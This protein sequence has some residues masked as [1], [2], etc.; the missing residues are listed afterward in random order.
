MARRRN[1]S[2]EN[3]DGET[4]G[5]GKL[6]QNLENANFSGAKL[7]G[8]KFQKANLR[9]A[10]F[11][12]AEIGGAKFKGANLKGANFTN[13]SV[14]LDGSLPE[15]DFSHTHIEGT[16]FSDAVLTRANFSYAETGLSNVGR[17]LI[18]VITFLISIFSAFPTAIITTFSTYF[19]RAPRKKPSFTEQFLVGIYAFIFTAFLRTLLINFN[20]SAVSIFLVQIGTA[21][22]VV[23]LVGA[24]IGIAKDGFKGDITSTLSTTLP[25]LIFLIINLLL[26]AYG[27]TLGFDKGLAALFPALKAIVPTLG[28]STQ[29]R[30]FTAI[31]GALIGAPFGSWFAKSAIYGD[32]KF[33]WLWDTYMEFAARS[34]TLFISAD[35]TD[36]NFVSAQVRGA[37]F[38]GA[39]LRRTN[40][41]GSRSLNFVLHENCYL[42]NPEI[43]KIIRGER[44]K[45]RDFS[46]LNLEGVNLENASL[47]NAL[48][49]E[50]NLNYA[51]LKGCNLNEA[52]FN[53]ARLV[54]ANLTEACLTG[55]CIEG[56]KIDETTILDDVIC[57]YV[58]KEKLPG[59]MAGR[60]REPPYPE[61]FKSG[62]F[63]E[64]YGKDVETV[65]FRIRKSD[66]QQALDIALRE[67]VQS[68]PE[69]RPES[70][71]QIKSIGDD[72]II[73]IRV[74][75]RTDKAS[76]EQ[77]FQRV[78]E[79]VEKERAANSEPESYSDLPPLEFVLNVVKELKEIM[80]ST[81]SS[82][83]INIDGP[84]GNITDN[85]YGDQNS[86]QTVYYNQNQ[87]KTIVE[88]AREIQDLIKQLEQSSPSA[89][90]E[91]KIEYVNEQAPAILRQ[92]IVKS[93]Q[94]GGIAAIDEVLENNA[95]VSVIRAVAKAWIEEA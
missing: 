8:A 64:K 4:F 48:F 71:Q 66:N 23:V 84:V 43:R 7:R 94:A 33:D 18:I 79:S 13:A 35:L 1:Y 2:G 55:A 88:S 29:D 61:I 31:L 32:K 46:K 14:D 47:K 3:L 52:N 95:Y 20:L 78:Y 9:N 40:W 16:D 34:G 77:K 90:E 49:V 21:M 19:L 15:V 39:Q 67:V 80:S 73:S 56:W 53:Q 89:S 92:K 24:F 76:I 83:V 81:D 70:F 22:I 51:K 82:K 38:K 27:S 93:L 44:V 54:G 63:K 60:R 72:V 75:S 59:N 65:Q 45:E 62:E 26:I 68:N 74:P 5:G 25:L 86:E 12:G 69:I 42:Q 85:I 36:A 30:W 91:E 28:E 87:E 57:E 11:S 50:T 37:N 10:D 41:R 17:I 6:G 58:F